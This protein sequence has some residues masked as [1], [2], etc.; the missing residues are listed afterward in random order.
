MGN[1]NMSYMLGQSVTLSL[2]YQYRRFTLKIEN[3]EFDIG[4]QHYDYSG[5]YTDVFH[6]FTFG[7]DYAFGI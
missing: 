5:A 1:L 2:G 3:M 7:A 4:A 6:G